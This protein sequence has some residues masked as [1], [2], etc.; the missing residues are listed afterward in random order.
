MRIKKTRYYIPYQTVINGQNIYLKI[1]LDFFQTPKSNKIKARRQIIMAEVEFTS[2]EQS[3]W[4]TSD[5]W[6]NWFKEDIT[7]KDGSSSKS[8]AKRFGKNDK[9]K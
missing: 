7:D 6:P 3:D 1:E 9:K 8:I 4:F 5:K 2:K